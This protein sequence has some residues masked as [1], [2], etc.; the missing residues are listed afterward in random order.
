METDRKSWY[1]CHILFGLG[2]ILA[3]VYVIV[4]SLKMS[5]PLIEKGQATP[6]DMPGLSPIVCS[7][8]LILLSL[9]VIASA[10]RNGGTLKHLLSPEVRNALVRGE[11]VVVYKVFSLMLLYIYGL[12]PH[13][14]YWAST[15]LFMVVFM[16]VFRVFSW[17]TIVISISTALLIMVIFGHLFGINLPK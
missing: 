6:L 11:A 4:D 16:A 8:L 13:L 17:R 15:S 12:L 1:T 3:S 7:A 10:R 2:L 14:P 5:L 9:V